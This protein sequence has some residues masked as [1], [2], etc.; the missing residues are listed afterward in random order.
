VTNEDAL[1][2]LA[3]RLAQAIPQNIRTA[4]EDIERNFRT[5]LRSGL[6]KMNLVSREEFDVQ[7]AV[8]ARTR[9][10]LEALEQSLAALEA[11][12]AGQ[13]AKAADKAPAAK[14]KKTASKKKAGKTAGKKTSDD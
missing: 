13:P 7:A 9:Q 11:Q 1:Q 12:L 4:S 14:A 5:V 8:L 10:K 6:G 3:R 2:G